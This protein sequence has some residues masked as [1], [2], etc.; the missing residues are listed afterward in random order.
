MVLLGYKALQ[1]QLEGLDHLASV[2]LAPYCFNVRNALPYD[3]MTDLHRTD[4]GPAGSIGAPGRPGINGPPGLIGP[5]GYRGATGLNGPLGPPG[6]R[7][8]PGLNGAPG[9]RGAPGLAGALST[10]RV[11]GGRATQAHAYRRPVGSIDFRPARPS[12]SDGRAGP[13]RGSWCHRAGRGTR[14]HGTIGPAGSAG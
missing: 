13:S 11:R 2:F 5:R 14:T 12:R 9:P 10:C 7:G 1:G 4:A 3:L 6:P 8:L